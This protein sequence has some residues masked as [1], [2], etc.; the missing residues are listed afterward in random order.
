MF[1]LCSGES[2]KPLVTWH[3]CILI[4]QNNAPAIQIPIPDNPGFSQASSYSR[5]PRR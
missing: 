1:L 4:N 5:N 3:Q 2:N